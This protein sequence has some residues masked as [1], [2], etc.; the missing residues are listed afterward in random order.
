[1]NYKELL[2]QNRPCPFCDLTLN[3]KILENETAFLTYAIAPYHADHL[4]VCTKR[5]VEHILDL[6]P[7]EVRDI[8]DLQKRGFTALKKMNYKNVSLLV[9]DG[10]DIGKS[11]KHIHYH[12]IPEVSL[13][14]SNH[15]GIDRPILSKEECN[16]LVKRFNEAIAN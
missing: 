1:M 7:E 4:L 5:H 6:S 11:V 13:G 8:D 10:D 16:L 3:E 9:R 2:E 12:L 14:A 15:A